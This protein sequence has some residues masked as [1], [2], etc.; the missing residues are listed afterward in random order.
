MF[1][2]MPRDVIVIGEDI[3]Y[4]CFARVGRAK[5]E[6]VPKTDI[7]PNTDIV[8][9]RAIDAFPTSSRQRPDGAI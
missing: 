9:F 8:R 1:A 6:T 5:K 4:F 7:V 2:R 3:C